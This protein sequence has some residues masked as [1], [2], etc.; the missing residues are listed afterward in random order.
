MGACHNEGFKRR[1]SVGSTKVRKT[2]S[3]ISENGSN[4]T[5]LYEKKRG[6]TPINKIN[7]IKYSNKDTFAEKAKIYDNDSNK[8]NNSKLDIISKMDKVSIYS[9]NIINNQKYQNFQKKEG[10][11]YFFNQDKKGK[12]N[13]KKLSDHRSRS[14]LNNL[15]KRTEKPPIKL[16]PKLEDN[17]NNYNLTEIEPIFDLTKNSN[18]FINNCL[19]A[20]DDESDN[21]NFNKVYSNNIE[22]YSIIKMNLNDKIKLSNE[23]L[24]LAER[25]WYDELINLSDLLMKTR[26][27]LDNKNFKSYLNRIIKI[28]EDFKWLVDSISYFY[29]NLKNPNIQYNNEKIGL[30]EIKSENWKNY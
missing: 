21:D 15:I 11:I 24:I 23:I 25:K 19:Y 14:N 12:V 22:Y 27:K 18:N 26:D 16:I 3:E 13:N 20:I 9:E 4:I 2:P 29:I 7:N 17:K 30:P 10:E 28:Y 1:N 6:Q 5:Q 8:I